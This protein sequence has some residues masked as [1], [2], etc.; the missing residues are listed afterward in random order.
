MADHAYCASFPRHLASHELWG[1]DLLDAQIEIIRRVFTRYP[2]D[3][4]RGVYLE[5]L[6]LRLQAQ[7]TNLI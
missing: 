3:H 5:V 7:S 1:P 6:S 4:A 2:S